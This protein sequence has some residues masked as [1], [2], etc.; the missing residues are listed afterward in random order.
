MKIKQILL[1]TLSILALSQLAGCYT[2]TVP[3]YVNLCAPRADHEVLKLEKQETYLIER[4]EKRIKDIKASIIRRKRKIARS[5]KK[6]DVANATEQI[7]HLYRYTHPCGTRKCKVGAGS[8]SY[9]RDH[10]I[11]E[12]EYDRE[13][14]FINKST[15][16]LYNISKSL[17]KSGKFKV[18]E[19]GFKNI[20]KQFKY[21]SKRQNKFIK[22]HANIRGAW[23]KQLVTQADKQQKSH[24]GIAYLKYNK[25]SAV[26]KERGNIELSKKITR[27]ASQTKRHIEQFYS[28]NIYFHRPSGAASHSINGV[29]KAEFM[30]RPIYFRN[31]NSN[32]I[33]LVIKTQSSRPTFRVYSTNEIGTF[34][35]SNGVTQVRNEEHYRIKSALSSAKYSYKNCSS[36]CEDKKMKIDTLNAE[37]SSQGAQKNSNQLQ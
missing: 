22:F 11:I 1:G 29:R 33:K 37:L 8:T 30:G 16:Q 17:L 24:P 3:L 21:D 19:K 7:D 27:K 32:A 4:Y 2:L 20:G 28:Y 35:Y 36:D 26:A 12:E 23:I 31:R 9:G 15:D 34:Q 5:L 25:A 10:I 6:K 13:R 18:L 14:K